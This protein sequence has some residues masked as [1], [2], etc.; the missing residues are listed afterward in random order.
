MLLN[1]S[2]ISHFDASKDALLL[3][4]Q[5][6]CNYAAMRDIVLDVAHDDAPDHG[7]LIRAVEHTQRSLQALQA[8]LVEAQ[9][10]LHKLRAR[11]LTALSSSIATLPVELL[12][13]ILGWAIRGPGRHRTIT[14]LASVCETWRVVV[15]DMKWAFVQADWDRWPAWLLEDWCSRARGSPLVVKL[16]VSGVARLLNSPS[17]PYIRAFDS[18]KA[19]WETLEVYTTTHQLQSDLFTRLLMNEEINS[20][21]RLILTVCRSTPVQ[22]TIRIP[23]EASFPNLRELHLNGTFLTPTTSFADVQNISLT[24]SPESPWSQW[25][26][27][28]ASAS[29]LASLSLQGTTL[30]NIEGA[31]RLEL[32]NLVALRLLEWHSTEV[33][34]VALEHVSL[35]NL[36]QLVIQHTS[37]PVF[38]EDGGRFIHVSCSL[39]LALRVAEAHFR[40]LPGQ[41][42]NFA[43]SPFQ[44]ARTKP[45]R[46]F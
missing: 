32:P 4:L 35:P 36:R 25:T 22:N 18:H 13:D 19:T 31:S 37:N 12:S 44:S 21:R 2:L 10:M 24:L 33:I 5:R 7:A 23:N 29:R 41:P 3:G 15:L 8:D 6:S 40:I 28:L 27:T 1:P 16:G 20:V 34:L 14:S 45:W 39:V 30:R 26:S 11:T 42:L 9:N 46:Q 17:S 43:L 38:L